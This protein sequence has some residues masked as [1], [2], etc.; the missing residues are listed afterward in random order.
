MAFA[1]IYPWLSVEKDVVLDPRNPYTQMFV[2]INTGYIP[3]V[4]LDAHCT[5]SSKVVIGN[6][7][8]HLDRNTVHWLNFVDYL[9]HEGRVTIPC[10][11]DLSTNG[12][13]SDA[14][15]TITINYGFLYANVRPLRRWQKFRFKAVPAPDGQLHWLYLG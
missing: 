15:L 9:G 12:Q 3:I 11:H 8:F 13:I 6:T 5:M 7:T 2:L 14:T 1:Q 10:F 4:N